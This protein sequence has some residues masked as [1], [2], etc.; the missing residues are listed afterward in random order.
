MTAGLSLALTGAVAEILLRGIGRP[1]W[2]PLF[3]DPARPVI[4]Q[5][6]PVLGWRHKEGDY[7]FPPFSSL[8]KQVRMRFLPDGGRLTGAAEGKGSGSI[9][10][11]GGSFTEGFAI[12]DH[13]TFA[14]KLQ[15]KFP[16]M[17]V[18]NYGT[19]A[20]GTYQSLLTLEELFSR[21]ERPTLALYGFFEGHQGRNVAAADWLKTLALTSRR[22]DRAIAVPH[23]TLEAGDRLVRRPAETY[24]LWPLREQSA[25]VTLLQ[26]G[27]ASFTAR[28]RKAQ[29]RAVTERLLLEMNSVC[30]AQG[31]GFLVVFLSLNGDNRARYARFLSEQGVPYVDCVVPANPSLVVPGDGHPNGKMNSRWS[32]CIAAALRPRLEPRAS[33][34]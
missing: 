11:V 27:H 23:A 18:R 20:Y 15:Q 5:P 33:G 4:Y 2:S 12:S 29:S 16:S 21:G 14:W 3:N 9:V 17:R 24:P 7:I 22:M 19:G 32:S 1:P 34:D 6:D 26:H 28:S 31:T 25:V 8:T 30:E 10:L 13:E